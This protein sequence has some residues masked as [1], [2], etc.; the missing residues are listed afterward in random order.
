MTNELL[1]LPV[2]DAA[3]EPIVAASRASDELR[4][5]LVETDEAL[6]GL[7]A[8]WDALA[9]PVPFRTWQW[10]ECWWRHYRRAADRLLVLAV[11]D[12]AGRLVGIAPWYV[13]ASRLR[14]RVVRLLGSGE[15]CSDYLGLV[16]RE[17]D[18]PAVAA[19]VAQWLTG[20]G[21]SRWDL[22]ELVGVP[23]ADPAIA[24][25]IGVLRA[26]GHDSDVRADL[27]CWK[28]ELPGNWNELLKRVSRSRRDKA[29]KLVR[30]C[31]DVGRV[32]QREA[33]NLAEW[34][35]GFR[36][37]VELH[38]KRR[39]MLGE[40]GCFASPRFTSFHREVSQRMLAAGQLRLVWT[41]LDGRPVAVEYAFYG[42]DTLYCYQTGFEPEVA[43][44]R[45]GWL[46]IIGALRTAIERG[47]RYY[48]FLRGDEPYK[49]S[50][51]AQPIPLAALRVAGRRRCARARL[52]LWRSARAMKH[53]WRKARAAQCRDRSSD[54]K[55][56]ET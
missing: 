20:P 52:H 11:R 53:C 6:A 33:T 9:G 14:G 30:R 4:V 38:Q 5:T 31:Y 32:V 2:A 54:A 24:R 47:I 18:S 28:I 55:S 27:N 16:C 41:E 22:L 45:P 42:G 8:P 1:E 35:L 49:A 29:R 12:S 50:W 10:L 56:D 25:L 15:V 40:P 39:A 46:E 48:D 36:L 3:A 44:D 26:A 19:A 51:S 7:S 13:T 21:A 37:L 34:E 43:R 23:A 17:E